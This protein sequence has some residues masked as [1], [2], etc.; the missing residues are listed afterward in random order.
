MQAVGRQSQAKACLGFWAW[1]CAVG[2]M[3]WPSERWKN[4]VTWPVLMWRVI[5][6]VLV[7]RSL[8]LTPGKYAQ[9]EKPA[10][11]ITENRARDSLISSAN[12]HEPCLE[13]TSLRTVEPFV[14]NERSWHCAQR[15]IERSYTENA[16]RA[17]PWYF[18]LSSNQ[19]RGI[20]AAR[21]PSFVRMHVHP[22]VCPR[23]QTIAVSVCPPGHPRLHAEASESDTVPSR[24]GAG[25]A[26]QPRP[27]KGSGVTT[28]GMPISSDFL[29]RVCACACTILE[30]G[31]LCNFV[32]QQEHQ[33]NT[34]SS[35]PGT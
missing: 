7:F 12:V 23:F 16:A 25:T 8:F 10:K 35:G 2:L 6:Y 9:H 20:I 11:Q 29:Q 28:I 26:C 19:T 4:K 34:G 17:H 21:R 31:D 33:K 3:V 32:L 14:P 22:F 18:C 13:C 5:F 24:H 27:R 1:P 30:H 15:R